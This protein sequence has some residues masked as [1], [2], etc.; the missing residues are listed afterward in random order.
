MGFEIDFLAVGDGEKSGDAIAVRWGNLSGTRAEQK[1]LVIDGGTLAAGQSLVD[2][3]KTYYKTESV[4]AVISTHPDIDHASG[5]KVVLENLDFNVLLMHKP[6]DHA[7]EICELFKNPTTPTKLK[8]KLRKAITTAHELETLCVER[9]KKVYEPFEGTDLYGDGS[10]IVLGPSRAYYQLLVS[11]F[12]DTPEASFS[13]PGILQ[14][15]VAA[16]SDAIEWVAEK[17][18]MQYESLDDSGITSHENN[19]SVILLLAIDGQKLLLTSDAGIPALTAAANYAASRSI[20]LHDLRFMQVPH[21]GS[22]HNV[23]KTIL[24]RIKAGTAYVSAGATAPKHPAKKVTNALIRRG[25]S[26][27]VTAGRS[28]LHFYDSPQRSTYSGVS[29]LPFYDQVE[30]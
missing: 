20:A 18:D 14:K 23:G 15:A 16:A 5:L 3:V 4:D 30:K 26:V 29:S 2:H 21:H 10:A 13:V 27:F 12:R 6:W 28:L 9:G 17:M 24:N 25:S 11:Q 7:N 8:E 22:K 1:I 19:S